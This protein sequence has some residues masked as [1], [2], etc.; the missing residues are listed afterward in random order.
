MRV[1]HRLFC[2]RE[3]AVKRVGQHRLA[4]SAV[5]SVPRLGRLRATE[6]V[7]LC[8]LHH[9][10]FYQLRCCCFLIVL[11]VFLSSLYTLQKPRKFPATATDAAFHRSLGNPENLC[12][13]LVIHVLKI[14]QNHRL[15]QLRGQLLQS[16]LD[17][18]LQL[19]TGKVLL[20]RLQP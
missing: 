8:H 2:R 13:L 3:R 17:A 11:S 7:E 5:S 16:I 18:N 14:T 12:D 10:P 15:P 19:Q 1:E 9:L 6:L 20:L 4:L